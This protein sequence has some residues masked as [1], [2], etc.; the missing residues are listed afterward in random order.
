MSE[1]HNEY[2]VSD[3][4]AYAW[5]CVAL[6]GGAAAMM[7]LTVVAQSSNSAGFAFTLCVWG[8]LAIVAFDDLR[9]RGVRRSPQAVA[10]IRISTAPSGWHIG[11]CS[12]Q[13][14]GPAAVTG[15]RVLSRVIWLH[16][17]DP[18][19]RCEVLCIVADS[20]SETMFR[21]L[22]VSAKQALGQ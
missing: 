6:H 8:A 20:M 11:Y 13:W 9:R 16:L 4:I 15:G 10:R 18:S 7:L 1:S 19:G 22:R 2:R 5:F 12:G 3:S 14:F 17:R 21:R